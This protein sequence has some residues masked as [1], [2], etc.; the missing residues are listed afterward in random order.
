MRE[1]EYNLDCLFIE[2]ALLFRTDSSIHSTSG[3]LKKRKSD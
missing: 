3:E 2:M 1:G